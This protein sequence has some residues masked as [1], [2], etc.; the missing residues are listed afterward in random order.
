MNHLKV[1]FEQNF[2]GIAGSFQDNRAYCSLVFPQIS[3]FNLLSFSIFSLFQSFLFSPFIFSDISV[4][5]FFFFNLLYFLLSFF[6]ILFFLF[7]VAWSPSSQKVKVLKFDI[8]NATDIR[9]SY[10]LFCFL[11]LFHLLCNYSCSLSWQ[12]WKFE[13]GCLMRRCSIKVVHVRL[14][15]RTRFVLIF[16]IFF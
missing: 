12:N 13:Y 14:F 7:F 2:L 3:P 6:S 4:Q 15:S 16:L 5:S 1:S 9:L 11:L 10:F 8:E